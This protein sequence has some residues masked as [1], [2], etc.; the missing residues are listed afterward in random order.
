MAGAVSS[1]AVDQGLVCSSL[2]EEEPVLD[3]GFAQRTVGCLE[4][5]GFDPLDL[6]FPVALPLDFGQSFD[7]QGGCHRWGEARHPGPDHATFAI[8]F[9]N[10]SGVTGKETHI[11]DLPHGILTFAET[12]LSAVSLPKSSAIFRS[13]ASKLQRRLRVLPGAPV[14]LRPHSLSAGVWSGILHLSDVGGHPFVLP[15]PGGEPQFGRAHTSKFVINQ[16][17][18]VGCTAYMVGQPLL[19]GHMPKLLLPASWHKSLRTLS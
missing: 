11:M 18:I 12:H 4:S 5:S 8:S 16:S 1:V 13:Y 17:A 2:S 15:W 6:G 3:F 10:P 19:V 7:S 9:S 14:S